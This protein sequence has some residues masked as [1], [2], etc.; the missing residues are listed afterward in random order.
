MKIFHLGG[1]AL[2]MALA[3]AILGGCGGAHFLLGG[4]TSAIPNTAGFHHIAPAKASEE[5]LYS[6]TGGYDGGTAATG[7][8]LDRHGNLYGTTAAGGTALC[9]TIF[10]LK[11]SA[12]P[13][14][15]ETVL[16]N[17]TCYSDGKDPHGGVTFDPNGN[18]DGTTVAGGTGGYCASDGCGVVYSLKLKS[19]NERVLYDFTGGNDGFG[20]GGGV[21]Y[22]TTGDVFGTT[23][24]GGAY[25]QGVVYEI[26]HNARGYH[27][28]VIHAFTGGKDGGVGSLGL[29]LRD[30]TGNLF[31][32]AEIGG[33][34]HSAGAVYRLSPAGHKWNFTTLYDFQ[35]APDA[36][37]PY[38]GL[39]E[40]ASGNL[41]GTTYYGGTSGLGTVFEL[42]ALADGKYRE[43]V[44]YS[45]KGG[46][47][48][49]SPLSTLLFGAPGQLYGTTTA[50]GGSCD[51][52][53]IFKLDLAAHTETVLHSFGNGVDGAS[54]LYGLTADTS[55]NMYGATELGGTSGQ[56]TVFKFRP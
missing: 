25:S 52:G 54:P 34:T 43:R 7:V 49:S 13:P 15:T 42:K 26:R 16:H 37:G 17:F 51:C 3:A 14:W 28:R 11:P 24:D 6:F 8:V 22:D 44:L 29:L 12:N 35:G 2:S 38:G 36:S 27:E 53:T 39:I 21:I 1:Y 10:K 9:G 46:S 45:F 31:G 40:D 50:G 5:V 23:P 55:G 48:G 47:D 41:Y 19:L 32:V 18:L 33:G 4:P 56:G 20:P 30:S